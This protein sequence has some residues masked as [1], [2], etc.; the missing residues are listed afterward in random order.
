[1]FV[2]ERAYLSIVIPDLLT[3][4]RFP[5]VALCEILQ[6]FLQNTNDRLR[7]PME[8]KRGY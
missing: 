6:H 8:S 5:N 1:M 4:L 2:Y 7:V 3:E